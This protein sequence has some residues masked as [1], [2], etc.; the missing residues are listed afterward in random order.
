MRFAVVDLDSLIQSGLIGAV[1]FYLVIRIGACIL[2]RS[3]ERPNS[4]LLEN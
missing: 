1:V 2:F 3:E 4:R